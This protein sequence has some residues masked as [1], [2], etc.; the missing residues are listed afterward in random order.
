[1]AICSDKLF[2][3][4]TV[5]EKWGKSIVLYD[6][7]FFGEVFS[8]E[9]LDTLFAEISNKEITCIRFAFT[10]EYI[11]IAPDEYNEDYLAYLR[12]AMKKAENYGLKIILLPI[13]KNWCSSFG[14]VGA[15]AW[16]LDCCEDASF[17]SFNRLFWQGKTY[18]PTLCYDGMHVQ[19][20]LQEH[21]IAAMN[22]TARRLK[23][24]KA[25]IGFE[26][27]Q[28]LQLDGLNEENYETECLLPFYKKFIE[29]LEVKH[30]HYTFFLNGVTNYDSL[31]ETDEEKIS[32]VESV[33]SS[34]EK[35]N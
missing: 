10:W 21:F 28:C 31:R 4:E 20:Y 11:E 34:L 32:S 5:S 12:R 23:M 29:T 2:G 22:H 30:S 14:G 17:D 26:L 6:G 25:V 27:F 13:Q 15:P 35:L 7:I 8:E 16:T 19:E 1:M 33:F 18:N 9:T 3:C 24:C